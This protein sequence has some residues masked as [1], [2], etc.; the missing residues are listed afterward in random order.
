MNL[1]LP[2]IAAVGIYNSQ[3][4]VKGKNTTKKRKTT[5]FE[6]EIPIENGGIS[7]INSEEMPIRPDTV[8]CAKPG[9][10]RYS[11]LPLK[12]YY[13]HIIIR[14]GDLYDC[15]MD[16]P[17]FIKTDQKEQYCTLFEK[18]S[19][20][21]E[22]VLENDE[23]MLHS[24]IL[25]LLYTLI[26]DSQKRAFRDPIKNSNYK[27]VEKAM[28]F[29]RENLTATLSLQ[30]VADLAGFSPIHFHNCFK[31][32]TGKTVH[33]YVE[34][35]RINKAANLLVTTDRTL[36]EIAYECGFSSQSYFSFAFK[37]RTGQTPREYAKK[38]LK[39]YENKR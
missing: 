32:S 3:I 26:N 12:C 24:L 21:S 6:I 30:T 23:L 7:Y 11:A 16:L 39:K 14:D 8:I 2:E 37:R 15:L 18:I 17:N 28:R 10:I 29:I 9:Q 35:Q 31:A 19:K 4:A 20:Y 38:I 25:E 27:A 1:I 22:T 36:T 5:M 13:I 33:E 34:E